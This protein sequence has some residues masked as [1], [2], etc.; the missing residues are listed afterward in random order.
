[1]LKKHGV[2]IAIGSDSYRQTS[3]VEVLNLHRL[4]VFDNL[5]LLKMW[6]ETTAATIFPQRKIGFLK[7]GYEAS[8]LV[9]DADPLQDFANVQKIYTRVKQGE[10][11]SLQP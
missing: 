8:F 4:K 11:L 7:E 2:R 1:V 3:L 9:L 10:I 5:T 6:C